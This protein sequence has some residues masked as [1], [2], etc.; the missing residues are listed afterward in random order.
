MWSH[1]WEL[2]KKK[3]KKDI[4]K[5]SFPTFSSWLWRS[6]KS[7]LSLL[8][9]DISLVCSASLE[10]R[11]PSNFLHWV[12]ACARSFSLFW[13]LRWDNCNMYYIFALFLKHSA[14][15]QYMKYSDMHHVTSGLFCTLAE[16]TKQIHIVCENITCSCSP[17]SYSLFSSHHLGR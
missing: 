13:F 2:E 4:R 6:L 1:F 8:F 10:L 12:K 15:W 11:F 5:S 3:Y 9:S 17:S 14:K 16:H 7:S